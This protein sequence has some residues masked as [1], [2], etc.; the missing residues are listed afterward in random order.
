MGWEFAFLDWIQNHLRFAFLDAVMPVI[1]F[2]G[3]GGWF[4]IAL[5]VVGFFSKHTRKYAFVGAIGLILCLLCGNLI[6]KPIIARTRPYDI[7]TTVE[8]LIPA[9]KDYSFPSG[10]TQ[11]SFAVATAVCMWNRKFGIP[12]LIL[13]S[14]IAFSRMYLYVHYPTDVLAGLIFGVGFAFVGLFLCNRIFRNKTWD[15]CAGAKKS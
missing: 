10:H 5:T 14:L 1:T 12:A 3:D 15:G 11:A 2:L 6:L 13:A 4:W 8:L 7:R 9:P